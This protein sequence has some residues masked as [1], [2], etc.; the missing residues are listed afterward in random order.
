MYVETVGMGI[1]RVHDDSVWNVILPTEI[2]QWYVMLRISITIPNMF[3][4][5]DTAKRFLFLG[6]LAARVAIAHVEDGR[7]QRHLY[8]ACQ[9]THSIRIV[10]SSVSLLRWGEKLR[11]TSQKS[12]H[13]STTPQAL[14]WPN[15]PL[16]SFK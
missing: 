1:G 8:T 5:V 15:S 12:R 11:P 13:A 7:V 16:S 4:S 6:L 3:N 2:H 9:I 14:C 10:L